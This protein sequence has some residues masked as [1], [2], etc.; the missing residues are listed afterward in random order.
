[1]TLETSCDQLTCV[2]VVGVGVVAADLE[3]HLHVVRGAPAADPAQHV[4]PSGG[5]CEEN[6]AQ[7]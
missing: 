5:G 1:M 3:D 4:S 7:L 6:R 2:D